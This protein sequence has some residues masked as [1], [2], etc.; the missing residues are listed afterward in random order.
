MPSL[1]PAVALTAPADV[2]VE[3]PVN[4]LARDLDLELLGDIGL[5]EGAAAVGADVGQGR[6]VNLINLIGSGRLAVGLGAV[7]FAGLAAGLFGLVGGLTLGE[8]SGLTLAGAGCLVELAAET[9]VLG[10]Q[11]VEASLKG[12]AS[13]TG[14]GLHTSIIGAARAA[15]ALPSSGSGISLTWTR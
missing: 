10:L 8:G 13:G 11:V 15:A 2:D 5:V 7:L 6:L 1:D 12:L 14:D 4:G 9:L 3:L